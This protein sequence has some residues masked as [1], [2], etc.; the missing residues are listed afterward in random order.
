M[1][2]EVIDH[3]ADTG[4]RVWASKP[5]ELF[6]EAARAMFEII[7]E[8]EGR[9]S[10]RTRSLK[11]QGLDLTDLLINWLRELLL[12]WHLEDHIVLSARIL[13]LNETMLSAEVLIQPFDPEKQVILTD[14]KAVTYHG[15]VVTGKGQDWEAQV[16]FDI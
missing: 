3:T 10:A 1:P 12:I 8:N 16:I 9:F 11:T 15:A 13:D 2:Y 4:I 14:V 5:E 6:T 7:A